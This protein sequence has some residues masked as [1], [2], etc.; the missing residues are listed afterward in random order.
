M[1]IFLA[2]EA[3]GL[4][5]VK[6]PDAKNVSSLEISAYN[7]LLYTDEDDIS[8]FIEIQKEIEDKKLD[9]GEEEN[10]CGLHQER[11]NMCRVYRWRNFCLG[12]DKFIPFAVT[13]PKS[14]L[15]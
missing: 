14:F 12:N 6:I 10:N 11:Q 8:K 15:V 3:A 2:L 7:G 5:G 4:I 13:D 9:V 1:F